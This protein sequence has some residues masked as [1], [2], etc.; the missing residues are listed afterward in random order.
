VLGVQ[1]GNSNAVALVPLQV[2]HVSL[3]RFIGRK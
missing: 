1:R 2:G 3:S